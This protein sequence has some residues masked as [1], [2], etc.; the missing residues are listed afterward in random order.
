MKYSIKNIFV[1]ASVAVVN[2]ACV[3]LDTAPYDR[4]TDLTF[5]SENKN[6]ALSTLNTCYTQLSSMDEQM[7]AECMSDN[8]YT[9]QPNDYTQ[10]I[11]NGSFSTADRYVA[12]F[13]DNRYSAIRKCNQ[14]LMNI[15]KVTSLSDDLKKRYIGEAKAIRAYHFYELYTRFG[16]IPYPETVISIA[17]SQTMERTPREAV[18]SHIIAD[19]NEII[20]GNYL[21]AS[22]DADNKGRITRGAAM[23]ILAKVY[24]FEGKW[25][26][27]KQLTQTIMNSN[28]YRL[29]PSYTGLF[30]VE[31]EG[32][33]EI[34]LDVQYTPATREQGTQYSFLPP[35]LGGY[36]QLSPLQE[37]V[38]SYVM[39]NGKSIHEAGSGYNPSKPYENRDPRLA[40][41]VIY[42]GNSYKLADGSE[43]I[44]NCEK[45]AEKDG[46]GFSSDCSATGYYV[47]KYWDSH[48]RSSVGTSSLNT[49][50][51]RYADILLMNAEANAEL[52]TL[53][54]SVWN[55]TIGA[56]R[57]RAGFP[58]EGIAFPA[59][60]KEQLINIVR[61]ERRSELAM[62]G[63][64]YKDIIRWRTAEKVLDGWCHGIHTGDVVGADDGFIRVENRKFDASKHY[65]WPI[66]QKE[67]D[68]NKDLD[69]NPNW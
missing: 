23:A 10:N 69:Q 54:A 35:T 40:A 38:D 62:E 49:I 45:G 13:W 19:L 61:N 56:I 55:S 46:L 18:V 39:T 9:K 6:A 30:E 65:L 34:I 67:R 1:V 2:A 25:D 64:R 26:M 59:V 36:S 20:N 7:F 58:N 32:N 4:E 16:A 24:L 33:S 41:T 21:P 44:I 14:L 66:P 22:Y 60:S 15:D 28:T 17:E 48:Y 42:T 47:K 43:V 52:G 53:D 11:G 29:F 68:L 12:N 27:V 50:L 3:G 5:W 8:A 63:H 31:N 51:I 37:L 57:Q